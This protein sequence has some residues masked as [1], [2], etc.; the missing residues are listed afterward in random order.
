MRPIGSSVT[1]STAQTP[2][3]PSGENLADREL[4]IDI[5]FF[6]AQG[7]W[8]PT[9]VVFCAAEDKTR[10][11]SLW[12]RCFRG[13]MALHG[14]LWAKNY[15]NSHFQNKPEAKNLLRTIQETG[16]VDN[17]TFRET[18][19]HC[20]LLYEDLEKMAAGQVCGQN[21]IMPASPIRDIE[22]LVAQHF[23][24]INWSTE[25]SEEFF[26]RLTLPTAKNI[27]GL[28][29][30]LKIEER[31]DPLVDQIADLMEKF[32]AWLDQ[33]ES[34]FESIKIML[35]QSDIFDEKISTEKNKYRSNIC[36]L[37]IDA[38]KKYRSKREAQ[39]PTASLLEALDKE[40]DY[41]I[42]KGYFQTS[43]IGHLEESG[44][45]DYLRRGMD[46]L[47]EDFDFNIAE[48]II[49]LP[50]DRLRDQASFLSNEEFL[51]LQKRFKQLK[52]ELPRLKAGA[53]CNVAVS[54]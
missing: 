13:F 26:E 46:G 15:L 32:Q 36:D 33:S 8:N 22:Q 16:V 20:T 27:A 6:D 40:K 52:T 25:A 45:L 41:W 39:E 2:T 23:L 43:F 44:L 11:N 30:K 49:N 1:A 18:V 31:N 28:I 51:L 42:A 38:V 3:Q 14:K 10:A 29:K 9:H 35:D 24:K 12:T 21:R 19:A 37:I 47:D 7:R 17:K 54:E 5:D 48:R 53:E 50:A 34:K 4:L